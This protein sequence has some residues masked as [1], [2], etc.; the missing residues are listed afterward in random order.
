MNT[1]DI[2]KNIRLGKYF[3]AYE[4]C[5]TMDG[6][7]IIFPHSELFTKLDKLREIVGSITITSGYRTPSYNKSVGGSNNSNHVKGL[8]VDIKFDFKKWNVSELEGLLVGIGFSNIGIY[9]D[10]KNNRLLWIH[11]DEG[12]RWDPGNGWYHVGNSAVKHYLK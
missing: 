2:L 8:A 4:F 7:A 12:K 5:N 1:V 11:V 6:N 9:K 3:T 10:K